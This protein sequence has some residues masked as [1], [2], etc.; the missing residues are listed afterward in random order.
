VAGDRVERRPAPFTT[1]TLRFTPDGGL[2]LAGH[3]RLA[4]LNAAVSR[5]PG[6]TPRLVDRVLRRGRTPTL[7]LPAGW[8]RSGASLDMN[9]T[10]T[11]A[12]GN[13]GDLPRTVRLVP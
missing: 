5:S 3:T 4:H 6:G 13:Y 1:R 7:R 8:L 2:W 9:G 11:D 12:D 10:V